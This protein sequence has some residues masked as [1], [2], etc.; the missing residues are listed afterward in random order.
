[1]SKIGDSEPLIEIKQHEYERWGVGIFVKAAEVRKGTVVTKFDGELIRCFDE[2]GVRTR[3]DPRGAYVLCMDEKHGV[4]VNCKTNTNYEHPELMAHLVN[5][6]HPLLPVPYNEPN[7]VLWGDPCEP[8]GNVL[9]LTKTLKRGD[10]ILWDY[11]SQLVKKKILSACSPSCEEC[12]N[13]LKCREWTDEESEML[14]S[15]IPAEGSV[16]SDKRKLSKSMVGDECSKSPQKK[17]KSMRTNYPMHDG[18]TKNQYGNSSSAKTPR[19]QDNAISETRPLIRHILSP[20]ASSSDESA[21]TSCSGSPVSEGNPGA[22]ASEAAQW[23]DNAIHVTPPLVRHILSPVASSS[24]ESACTSR[25]GSPVSEGNPGAS[26]SEAAQWQDNAII[27]TPPLVRHILSPV[28]TSSETS[29]STSPLIRHIL[30]PAASSSDTSERTSPFASPLREANLPVTS[31]PLTPTSAVHQVGLETPLARQNSGNSSSVVFSTPPPAI[32]RRSSAVSPVSGEFRTPPPVMNRSSS[33]PAAA[34]SVSDEFRTPPAAMNRSMSVPPAVST[35]RDRISSPKFTHIKRWTYGNLAEFLRT[36]QCSKNCERNCKS[37]DAFQLD[38]LWEWWT[39]HVKQFDRSKWLD[40][41]YKRM[42]TCITASSSTALVFMGNDVCEKAFM[43]GN[44]VTQRTFNDLKKR[45]LEG[46]KFRNWKQAGIG[47]RDSALGQRTSRLLE[48]VT[49]WFS[50]LKVDGQCDLMPI[51]AGV[52]RAYQYVMPFFSKLDTYE[53]FEADH[54]HLHSRDKPYAISSSRFFDL[55]RDNFK[56]VVPSHK[57]N[58]S[59]FAQCNTCGEAKK[60]ILHA[61][62][63]DVIR[64]VRIH[65]SKHLL[66]AKLERRFYFVRR[67]HG[68]FYNRGEVLSMIIDACDYNKFGLIRTKGRQTKSTDVPVLTQSLQTVLVH[69]RGIFQYSTRPHVNEG[70]GTNFTIECLMRT[71]EKLQLQNPST[72]LPAKLYLQ[73]DNCTGANKNKWILAFADMLVRKGVFKEVVLSFLMVGHTHE[74]IDQLFSIITYKLMQRNLISPES[75]GKLCVGALRSAGHTNVHFEILSF[76]HDYKAWLTPV[77]DDELKG[78]TKP[79]VFSF[80][81]TKTDS[82]A[83]S[84]RMRYKHWH[85]CLKWYP[86]AV[87]EGSEDSVD[88]PGATDADE[89][90]VDN[91]VDHDEQTVKP[92]EV[93]EEIKELAITH[94]IEIG[95]DTVLLD[96]TNSSTLQQADSVDLQAEA[97]D[98]SKPY[99]HMLVTTRLPMGGSFYSN[100]YHTK[101]EQASYWASPG[102]SVVDESKLADLGTPPREPFRLKSS[103]CLYGLTKTGEK[104]FETWKGNVKGLL[105]SSLVNAFPRHI[106]AWEELFSLHEAICNGTETAETDTSWTFRWPLPTTEGSSSAVPDNQDHG[107]TDRTDNVFFDK[108]AA[109]GESDSDDDVRGSCVRWAG[110]PETCQERR[111]ARENRLAETA[112]DV[113]KDTF[114]ICARDITED[115]WAGVAGVHPDEAKLPIMLCQVQTDTPADEQLIPVIYYRA[116]KGNPNWKWSPAMNTANKLIGGHVHRSTVL[117]T[118]VRIGKKSGRIL[119]RDLRRLTEFRGRNSKFVKLPFVWQTASSTGKGILV[120]LKDKHGNPVPIKGLQ[121]GTI[122]VTGPSF[123]PEATGNNNTSMDVDYSEDEAE[124][125]ILDDWQPEAEAVGG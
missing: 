40:E 2:N 99:K 31:L 24:D 9:K 91:E 79:H 105:E 72:P 117:L 4:Y 35:S 87:P 56:D 71:F 122:T 6:S 11:H 83:I 19:W 115:E 13:V 78:Y 73:M 68:E 74:D 57:Q 125:P 67:S 60:K 27:V 106:Q 76:Q 25:S 80:S 53:A 44:Y 18:G 8:T 45:A 121:D 98:A 46:A 39:D 84:V 1:M 75:M 59:H 113:K 65:R 94:H 100:I 38:A 82:G 109:A 120:H 20:V 95:R 110:D 77:L 88:I 108:S 42:S 54:R 124:R 116:N 66:R 104:R 114:L 62:N 37:L 51:A 70:G 28:A 3:E 50:N 111:I 5:S 86:L 29:E 34:C 112:V 23:Q 12:Q 7:A 90:K 55:W 22:S 47:R 64:R 16:L 97:S 101:K 32:T 48:L 52:H 15:C 81:G 96:L 14:P 107:A 10:E 58:K 41:V 49:N 30:S 93:S 26:A 63:Q 92:W 89:E 36:F 102:L 119:K 17:S 21:C 61:M 118:N 43:L 69:G 123:V 85:R 33:V 103:K